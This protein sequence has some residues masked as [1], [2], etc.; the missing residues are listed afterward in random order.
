[1]TYDTAFLFWPFLYKIF[2]FTLKK[3]IWAFSLNFKNYPPLMP[4]GP[5]RLPSFRLVWL[6]HQIQGCRPLSKG[7]VRW[8]IC[9][10]S[11]VEVLPVQCNPPN[12]CPCRLVQTCSKCSKCFFLQGHDLPTTPLGKMPF[13]WAPLQKVLQKIWAR[14]KVPPPHSGP[15]GPS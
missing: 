15:A 5:G 7:I 6:L 13:Y 8:N 1:M 11:I 2:D 14:S 4:P 9:E 10:I 3:L 12:L